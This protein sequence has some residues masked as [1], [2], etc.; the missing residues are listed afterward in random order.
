MCYL[1]S[2]VNLELAMVKLV[3]QTLFEEAVLK[4]GENC[5]IR[6]E[7]LFLKSR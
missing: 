1:V 2:S 4:E 5:N 3:G 7:M 6:F